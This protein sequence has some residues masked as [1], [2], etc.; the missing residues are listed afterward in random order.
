MPFRLI[1]IL[2]EHK[3]IVSAPSAHKASTHKVSFHDR[4]AES[5]KELNYVTRLCDLEG[6][7]AEPIN[8]VHPQRHS[9]F[10]RSSGDFSHDKPATSVRTVDERHQNSPK[11]AR[12]VYA[13]YDLPIKRQEALIV[14]DRDKEQ[15][16][17]FHW[18]G[19]IAESFVHLSR[20]MQ[21]APR[22]YDVKL[23][24]LGE[25]ISI[26][27][28][29]LFRTPRQPVASLQFLGASDGLSVVIE[30]RYVSSE[31]MGCK[32]TKPAA[33]S[34]IEK[35]LAANISKNRGKSFLG[36]EN[37]LFV[38]RREK[39]LPVLAEL[40]TDFRVGP[41]RHLCSLYWAIRHCVSRAR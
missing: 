21:H 23:P 36:G 9:A 26:E 2:S 33:A 4:E 13:L 30:S 25:V 28:G 37:S 34:S 20:V 38:N 40:K 39:P 41:G 5:G 18:Y 32:G 10:D 15:P 11:P 6:I 16:A 29:A 14:V 1:E 7:A 31:S 3:L 8:I 24:E 35:R 19:D 27:H 17:W 12:V 22:A